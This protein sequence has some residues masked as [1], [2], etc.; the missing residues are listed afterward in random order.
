ML[1]NAH[2][3]RPLR[4][5]LPGVLRDSDGFFTM[6]KTQARNGLRIYTDYLRIVEKLQ[7]FYSSCDGIPGV[8]VSFPPIKEPE[9][10][11]SELRE[12]FES[13]G[14]SPRQRSSSGAAARAHPR[15]RG[16]ASGT[17]ARPA[18]PAEVRDNACGCMNSPPPPSSVW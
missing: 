16:L 12:Y 17:R 5:L 10:P 14:D 3:C 13:L 1:T 8:Y 6:E 9:V 11:I 15:G 2:K 4:V 18:G 7:E